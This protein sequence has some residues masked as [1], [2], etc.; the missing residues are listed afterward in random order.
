MKSRLLLCAVVAG[1]VA[2][3]APVD[4][5]NSR[6]VTINPPA[7]AE[8]SLQSILD[9]LYGCTGCINAATDQQSAGEWAEPGTPPQVISPVIQATYTAGGDA[10]GIWSGTDSTALTLVDI[11]TATA[12]TGTT[13]SILFNA[14]GSISIFSTAASCAGS[15]NCGDFT[16]ITQSAFGFYLQQGPNTYYTADSLNGGTAYAVAYQ[17]AATDKWAIA[18]EDGT[19]FDYND[20]VISVES[21]VGV[22]EPGALLLLG[23]LATLCAGIIRRRKTA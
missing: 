1:V 13:A 21:I 17:Q 8:A 9:T 22:P 23:T 2:F 19:D 4:P 5:T 18:F 12:P 15:V 14:D 10:V 20:R 3:G 16:G 6:P 11:F 7:G